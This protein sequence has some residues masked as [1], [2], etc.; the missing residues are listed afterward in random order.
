MKKFR[1]LELAHSLY[2]ET[3][4]LKFKKVHFQDQYD[5]ALL[6]IVL[7]LSEGSGRRTAKDRRRFYFMSYSSLK[8]VQTILRLNRIDK[9]DSKFDTLAAHLYQLTKNPG[10][11]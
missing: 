5:R 8:E 11:H 10:G 1:T 9:F 4:E 2:E 3:V 7:N 6:S